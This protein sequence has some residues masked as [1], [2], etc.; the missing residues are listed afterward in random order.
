MGV[1]RNRPQI[2]IGTRTI[3]AK[4]CLGCF[5]LKPGSEFRVTY[6]GYK[7]SQCISCTGRMAR[8]SSERSNN[9]TIDRAVSHRSEWTQE[10]IDLVWEL[11][12]KGMKAKEIAVFLGRSL[13]SIYM[14][15]N[16]HPR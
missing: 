12:D 16:K 15:K 8:A 14:I 5:S 9:L 6:G 13:Y 10:K 4:T 11:T 7:H 2:V 1:N 3:L